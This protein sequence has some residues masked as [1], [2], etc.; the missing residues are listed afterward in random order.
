MDFMDYDGGAQAKVCVLTSLQI[1]QIY[2]ISGS[3]KN[4]SVQS[5]KSVEEWTI[6]DVRKQKSLKSPKSVEKIF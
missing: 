4:K 3:V 5:E 6:I 1:S 2:Q